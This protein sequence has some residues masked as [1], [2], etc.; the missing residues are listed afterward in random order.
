[1]SGFVEA[2]LLIKSKSKI[3]DLLGPKR[4]QATLAIGQAC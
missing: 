2:A 4:Y 1:M 3:F